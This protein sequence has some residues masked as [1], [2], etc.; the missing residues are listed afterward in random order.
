MQNYCFS[1]CRNSL[2]TCFLSLVKGSPARPALALIHPIPDNIPLGLLNFYR[3]KE[4]YLQGQIGNPEGEDVPTIFS[5]G[6]TT[7]E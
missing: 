7:P 3:A 4:G 6:K 1:T 2:T 5:R